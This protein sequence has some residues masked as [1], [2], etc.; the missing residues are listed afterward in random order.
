MTEPGWENNEAVPTEQ[1]TGVVCQSPN[2]V[3]RV[4]VSEGSPERNV[5]I[6]LD[7]EDVHSVVIAGVEGYGWERA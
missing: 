3:R 1:Q 6:E 5:G 7:K 2:G 4:A